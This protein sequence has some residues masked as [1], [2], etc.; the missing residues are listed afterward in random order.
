MLLNLTILIGSAGVSYYLI[1]QYK[2]RKKKPSLRNVNQILEKI[3]PH[4]LIP[5]D[6]SESDVEAILAQKLHQYFD[7]VKTQ[8]YLGGLKGSKDRIDIDIQDG[9]FGIEIKLA[10]LLRKSN[11]RNRLL[12][13]M[14][15]YKI[16]KYHLN[17]LM[18]IL[19]GSLKDHQK[20]VIQELIEILTE[21]GVY[22]FYWPT[23]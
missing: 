5:A 22:C 9:E 20:A 11:E 12:G 21:K 10:R 6:A 7:Q 16:R 19:V 13:Q 23:D 8:Y 2:K 4:T 1:Q 18:V 15:M 14:D 3:K 17:N